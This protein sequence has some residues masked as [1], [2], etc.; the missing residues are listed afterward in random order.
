MGNSLRI[1]KI[2]G[3]PDEI[4]SICT[5]L[6]SDG[7]EPVCVHINTSLEFENELASA[8]WDV[9]ISEYR[10]PGFD[11]LA[12]LQSWRSTDR[13]TPFIIYS[14]ED[15][16]EAIIT[17]LQA[18]ANDF[19]PKAQI[20]RLVTA[21]QRE[22]QDAETRRE[23]RRAVEVR[24]ALLKFSQAT[25]TSQTLEELLGSTHATIRSLMSADN[26]YIA[27]FDEENELL[28][29]PYYVD[30]FDEAPPPQKPGRGLTEYI[31]RS[32]QSVF[33]SPELF[34]D[35]IARDEVVLIGSP[36]IDWMGVPLKI[37][38]KVIGVLAVQSYLEGVRYRK[39]DLDIL[40]FASD[41]IA[42]AINRRRTEQA[43]LE[44]VIF[45]KAIERSILAGIFA[46]NRDGVQTYINP[47]FCQM[48]GWKESELLG[49][50][51]PY[52]YW[53]AEDIATIADTFRITTGEDALPSDFELRF[54]RKNGERFDAYLLVSPLRNGTQEVTEW[55]ASVYDISERKLNEDIIRRQT[56]RAEALARMAERLNARL[57]QKTVLNTVC[58]E[59]ASA[60]NV[61]AVAVI[62]YDRESDTFRLGASYG[63]PLEF[64]EGYT[65]V[66]KLDFSLP[67]R[68]DQSLVVIRDVQSY[69]NLPHL[70][71]LHKCNVRTMAVVQM[72]RD[73]R[74]TGYLAV[75]TFGK[76]Q[77]FSE[78]EQSLMNGL[79]NLAEQAIVNAR[80]FEETE[81]RLKQ[82]HA[83]RAIDLAISASL[84]VTLTLNILLDH[85]L[86]LLQV[87]AA[88]IL[89]YNP[90]SK[91]LEFTVGRGFRL[92]V[93]ANTRLKLGEGLASQAIINRQTV[94]IHNLPDN[95]SDPARAPF[96][97]REGFITYHGAPLIAKGEVKGVLELFHRAPL[98]QNQEWRELFDALAGQ[99]A[100]AIDNSTLF[101]QLQR[102][103]EE[104]TLAYDS[105]LEGWVRA[106]DLR[107]KETESHSH[108]VVELTLRVA[109]AMGV[110]EGDLI[111][112][113]R[114][115][116]LH[117][118]GKIGIS[119]QILMKPG[120]LSEEEW[121]EVK[122]HPIYAYKILYPITYLRPALDI[123]YCHHEY[124]DGSGY[125]RGLRAEEI[126]LA[127]RIF[128]AIDAWDS[129]RSDCAYRTAW[130]D[131]QALQYL[132]EQ[133]GRRFD[134]SVVEVVLK[135]IQ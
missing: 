57:D 87:D 134:P 123:P 129:L 76:E 62:L 30:Q 126:P 75:F 7:Y 93:P 16:E 104:L 31:L 17:V 54:Q 34:E 127:A 49:A 66:S 12:A 100:I 35:L 44:E 29:F 80:L 61:Q 110:H 20:H 3:L 120:P 94:Q 92:D 25:L 101:E 116:L 64:I 23:R 42:M 4:T 21:I 18:G 109:Q 117:D 108:R 78:D 70:N 15:S 22:L 99:A 67:L 111:H 53:P 130:S 91:Q 1:L 36:S 9:I 74:L 11:S 112:L 59:T 86:S 2:G 72:T 56:K 98:Q 89:L 47:A 60:I 40:T 39:E 85:V 37:E 113:Q 10:L 52:L 68:T 51:P 132:K 102:T 13:Y 82:V 125:P 83:L 95:Q 58:E 26:F 45:R 128:T 71:L 118:I 96:F 103:N 24:D 115:A 133:S 81:Q 114:G 77:S 33:A 63:F 122:Q 14:E 43:L 19:I 5:E 107:D 84:D 121:E 119:D 6:G 38:G 88:D 90:R 41:Q 46:F 73:Q 50:K 27:L 105:T 28:S 48:V 135:V 97:V 69:P 65:P 106:L 131:D 55:L 8:K 32:G 124:W 79:A